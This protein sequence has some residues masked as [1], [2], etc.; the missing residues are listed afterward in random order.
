MDPTSP[1]T[2]SYL[3]PPHIFAF[4]PVSGHPLSTRFPIRLPLQPGHFLPLPTLPETRSDYP[5]SVSGLP[6]H[7][8]LPFPPLNPFP[9]HS[10]NS[11]TQVEEQV[12]GTITPGRE[13]DM[14]YAAWLLF[15]HRIE[16]NNGKSDGWH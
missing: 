8:T 15:C 9:R 14:R 3:F 11:L 10:H 5:D 12:K 4:P 1:L 13:Y 7:V 16:E 6:N 2:S